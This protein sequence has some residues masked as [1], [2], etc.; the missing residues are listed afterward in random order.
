MDTAQ[1]VAAISD[2]EVEKNFTYYNSKEMIEPFEVPSAT[3]HPPYQDEYHVKSEPKPV[4]FL[5]ENPKFGE[6]V[7][8]SLSSVHVPANVYDRGK[9]MQL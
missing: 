3:L 7:N 6:F 5:T 2:E 9:K 8:L 1:E 4:M